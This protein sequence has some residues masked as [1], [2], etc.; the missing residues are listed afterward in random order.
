MAVPDRNPDNIQKDLNRVYD[1]LVEGAGIE[2]L[3][4]SDSSGIG[5]ES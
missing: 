4:E 2:L 1:K 5:G 3:F